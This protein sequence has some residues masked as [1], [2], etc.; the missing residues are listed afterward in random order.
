M[1]VAWPCLLAID[2]DF[3]AHGA[4]IDLDFNISHGRPDKM[5]FDTTGK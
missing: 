2:H 1:S 4:R 3:P 5:P